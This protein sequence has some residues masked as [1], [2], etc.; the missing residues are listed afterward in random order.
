MTLLKSSDSRKELKD[1]KHPLE[2]RCNC[3]S[4]LVIAALNMKPGSV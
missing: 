3:M 1:V 2:T 4:S